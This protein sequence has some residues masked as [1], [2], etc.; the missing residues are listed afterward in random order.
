MKP[1]RISEWID[2][3]QRGGRYAFTLAELPSAHF[4]SRLTILQGLLRLQRKNRVRRLRREFFVILPVEYAR[5]GM[6]PA[7]WFIDDLMAYLGQPYYVGLFSA[8]ALH[9]ASHQQAQVYQVVTPVLVRPIE[10]AGL[11]LRFIQKKH[12]TDTPTQTVKGHTGMLP[13]STPAATALDLVAYA[14][15]IGGLDAILTPLMEL[16]EIL[17]LDDLRESSRHEANLS[18]VQRTGWLLE[19]LG[20]QASA[21]GLAAALTDRL[22]ESSRVPLDPAAPRQGSCGNRWR[23]IVNA[24]PEGDT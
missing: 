20:E 17:Q 15:R 22:G 3:R 24:Q 16:S 8:A 13:V 5:I 18:V 1:S 6:I 2:D 9:G 11:K 14:N 4:G 19:H 10:V 7:D 12:F 23:I 21:D